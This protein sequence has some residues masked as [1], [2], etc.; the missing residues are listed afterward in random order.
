MNNDQ[1]LAE[2]VSASAPGIEG[3][4]SDIFS[5][6]VNYRGDL[7]FFERFAPTDTASSSDA[8]SEVFWVR[9]R[10]KDDDFRVSATY[11]EPPPR[12]TMRW[13]ATPATRYRVQFKARLE[14]L[15]W[16][17]LA[18]LPSIG[19]GLATVSLEIESA[20]QRFYQVVAFPEPR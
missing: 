7:L 1:S 3:S 9:L 18:V 12:L 17:E 13:K 4:V 5:T 2:R 19:G 14:E 8:R 16:Q 10:A 15:V 20:E 11:S 6:G